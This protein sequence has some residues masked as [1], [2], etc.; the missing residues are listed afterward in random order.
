MTAVRDCYGRL[1][2]AVS[3]E[4]CGPLVTA[5]CV[6]ADGGAYLLEAHHTK[7]RRVP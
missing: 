3:I 5:V 2:R 4:R 7:V 1:H 6:R